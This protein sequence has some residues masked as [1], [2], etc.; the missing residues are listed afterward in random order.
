MRARYV[1][2]ATESHTPLLFPEFDNLIL[3]MQ[4]QAAWGASDGGTMKGGVGISTDRAFYGRH[5]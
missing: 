3:P 1:I 5:G 4:T 2:N